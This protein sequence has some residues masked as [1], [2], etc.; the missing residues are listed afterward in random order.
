MNHNF[1]KSNLFPNFPLFFL[2]PFFSFLFPSFFSFFFLPAPS[3]SVR[4]G[5]FPVASLSFALLSTRRLLHLKN[6]AQRRADFVG[7]DF[8]CYP[9]SVSPSSRLREAG[10]AQEQARGGSGRG[11]FRATS[12]PRRA[13]T[14]AHFGAGRRSR[15]CTSRLP[16]P[17]AATARICRPF[18]PLRAK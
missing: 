2:F 14:A 13:T 10:E 6:P 3:V 16:R 8:V 9:L 17:A 4:D 7:G 12:R 1:F 11:S 18:P 5:F 15:K